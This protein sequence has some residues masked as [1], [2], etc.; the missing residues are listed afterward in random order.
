[1][2]DV[3]EAASGAGPATD[4][5]AETKVLSSAISY[6][7]WFATTLFP[8]PPSE[9]S[10]LKWVCPNAHRATDGLVQHSSRPRSV[11]KPDATGLFLTF[12]G[13]HR[14]L[15]LWG[16][17]PMR[18]NL[19]SQGAS[20]S[21][22]HRNIIRLRLTPRHPWQPPQSQHSRVCARWFITCPVSPSFWPTL[23]LSHVVF[24]APLAPQDLAESRCPPACFRPQ[25]PPQHR[26]PASNLS[27]EE[28]RSHPPPDDAT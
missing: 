13:A 16:L 19:R 4:V 12:C 6:P 25:L 8:R 15:S 3:L 20:L 28:R 24:L 27:P 11:A 22:I 23:I 9:K 26:R 5:L 2:L 17:T 14:R 21:S 7:R 18:A 1:M 10:Q